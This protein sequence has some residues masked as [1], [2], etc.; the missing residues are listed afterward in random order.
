MSDRRGSEH[1]PA[2]SVRPLGIPGED[3]REGIESAAVLNHLCPATDSV[4]M[5]R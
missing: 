2:L 1:P 4:G 3:G 5:D